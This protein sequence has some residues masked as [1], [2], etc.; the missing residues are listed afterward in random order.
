MLKTILVPAT[1]DK[2][3]ASNLA[4]AF[5]LARQFAAHI[6]A[7]HV[8]PDPAEVA[9][10]L[11]PAHGGGFPAGEL[12][13]QLE[14]H[15]RS[16]QAQAKRVFS[17]FCAREKLV[18]DRVPDGRAIVPTAEW[19]V[20]A[21]HP[22][23]W[24]VTHGMTADLIIASRARENRTALSIL[25]AIL[26]KTG[27]PLLIPGALAPST[28]MIETI[29]IAWEATPEA[30]R[31]VT[32]ALPL[33]ARANQVTLMTVGEEGVR[34]DD[35]DRLVEYLAWHG[36]KA[37]AKRL[38]PNRDDPVETLLAAASETAGLL[39][40]GGYGHGRLREWIFG[41]FTRQA[42]DDAPMPVLLAH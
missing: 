26:V 33:L 20:E 16:R 40:M 24:M 5:V 41:G 27:R 25:E 29:A 7:L 14:Q 1:A 28:T 17:D 36:I 8:R 22:Q 35:A 38:T 21:G 15:A 42:L 2:S 12:I 4:T 19:R 18:V 3:D 39:V 31:A 37:T 10:A 13:D 6:V 30:A 9:V 23:H 32:F 34:G 11:T